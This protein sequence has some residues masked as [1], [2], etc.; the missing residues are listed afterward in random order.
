MVRASTIP[1]QAD[2]QEAAS[3]DPQQRGGCHVDLV[4]IIHGLHIYNYDKEKH[5]SITMMHVMH[6]CA[7]CHNIVIHIVA[8]TYIIVY[9][10]IS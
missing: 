8:H 9:Q 4:R 1:G 3:A 7:L 10:H 6:I 5:H 2:Q